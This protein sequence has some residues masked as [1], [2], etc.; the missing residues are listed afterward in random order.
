MESKEIRVDIEVNINNDKWFDLLYIYVL[1]IMK[2]I[3]P[4]CFGSRSIEL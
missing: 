3:T 2:Y 1:Q 4:L